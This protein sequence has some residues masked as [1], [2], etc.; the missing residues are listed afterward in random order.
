MTEREQLIDDLD[1][2][3]PATEMWPHLRQ[4]SM[5]DVAD[6]I[7]ADRKRII[8][9]VR[10]MIQSLPIKET[11]H[12]YRIKDRNQGIGWNECRLEMFKK[13]GDLK[14]VGISS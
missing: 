4:I 6:F 7:F 3:F 12:R 9:E 5:K 13:I 8:H 14:N 2:K 10:M 11:K 1:K